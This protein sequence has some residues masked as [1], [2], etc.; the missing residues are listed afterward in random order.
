MRFKSAFIWVC[1]AATGVLVYDVALDR[2]HP[3]PP[4]QRMARYCPNQNAAG[5]TLSASMVSSAAGTRT[6]HECEYR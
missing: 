5:R 3:M 1:G 4:A 2:Q 6:I